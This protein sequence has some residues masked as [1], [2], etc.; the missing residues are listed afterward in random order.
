MAV[1]TLSFIPFRLY[2]GLW[3]YVGIWD[4]KNIILGLLSSTFLFYLVTHWGFNLTNYPRSV[5]ILDTILL[6]F[7][8]GGV[9]LLKRFYQGVGYLSQGKRVLVY[10][11][12]DTGEMIVRNLKTNPDK[13]DYE[14]VG[15]IDDN[16]AM[17][18][19]RIH[20]E[21]SGVVMLAAMVIVSLVTEFGAISGVF[22]FRAT[23]A[24]RS[25]LS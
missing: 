10:G 15:F 16:L 24:H 11:A 25:Q 7:L 18:D 4:L 19:Q 12:G 3:R 20:N 21:V 1:R 14:A 9:R 22:G 23:F 8:L 13:Y 17:F 6:V 5:Y 2:E